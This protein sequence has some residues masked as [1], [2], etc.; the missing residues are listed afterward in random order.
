MQVQ[1]ELAKVDGLGEDDGVEGVVGAG[2]AR[3]CEGVD[4][5][6]I[7]A[8]APSG[9]CGGRLVKVCEGVMRNGK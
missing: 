8:D 6:V 2:V 1:K 3:L 4:E 5:L 9:D 7:F